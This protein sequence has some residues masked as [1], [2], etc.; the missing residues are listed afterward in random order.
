MSKKTW[1]K[2]ELKRIV[3]GSAEAAFTKNNEPGTPGTASTYKS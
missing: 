1:I 3:A 2:P